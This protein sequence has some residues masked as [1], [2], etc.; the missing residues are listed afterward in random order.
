MIQISNHTLKHF[1][2]RQRKKY[3]SLLRKHMRAAAANPTKGRDRSDIKPGYYSVSAQKH[4]IYYR[5]GTAHVEI[6]DV[7]RQSMEPSVHL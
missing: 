6:I 2:G 1:G 5:M 4:R 3:L 7:L